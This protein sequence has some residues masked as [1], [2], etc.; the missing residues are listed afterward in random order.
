MH[1]FSHRLLL[2]FAIIFISAFCTPL[3]AQ[4]NLARNISIHV[5]NQRL[6]SVFKTMEERG[7]FYFSYN[8]NL[9]KA[10][11]LVSLDADNWTV[12]EVLDRMLMKRFEY[13]D[14]KGFIILRY[15][16][17]QL[18]LQ[19]EKS[20]TE[21]NE[22]TITGFIADELTGKK[23]QNASVYE[24]RL[25]QSTMTDQNGYFELHLKNEGNPVRLTVSKELYK[26]TTITFLNDV[27]VASR[28]DSG[29]FSYI[30]NDDI[31]GIAKTGLG[32]LLLS[33]RQQIQAANL[34]GLVAN[35]PFQAS[36]IPNVSTHGALSGQIV[37]QV[38][39][40][41]LGG[42]NAG[43]RGFEMGI[44]F[45]L[46]KGDVESVQIAGVFNIVG[47]SV[48]GLQFGG[49]YNNVLGDVSG[50][51][52]A[53]LHNNIK[54][55]LSGVQLSAYNHVKGNVSGLQ[56][57]AGNIALQKFE[58]MQLGLFNF[59]K[60]LRGVQLGLINVADTSS[61]F[62]L[63]LINYVRNGYNKLTISPNETLNANISL[64]S[65][66]RNFYTVYTGGMRVNE[67]SKI[68]G[69]GMGLGTVLDMSNRLSF[70]PEISSR[71]LY[72]GIWRYTNLL[73]RLDA[74]L[75]IKLGKKASIFAGPSLNFYYTKQQNA[76][77]GYALAQNLQHNFSSNQ[78]HSWWLGWNAGFN[79][80]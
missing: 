1:Y 35:A 48:S 19:T 29:L 49:L 58:G 73:N 72:E 67:N 40:N 33:T 17:L 22:Y 43:V 20:V 60:K 39:L 37:N 59:A 50:L 31:E 28:P 21:N 64:K 25:L 56:I 30:A 36:V 61:G 52:L 75:N 54:R 41:A 4:V 3:A 80:F 32:R 9:V 12:K 2:F 7:S 8:S 45:N 51:Q 78:H 66:S 70:N 76:V 47:G 57:G 55:E 71:Y 24:K 44:I 10:D 6:G 26:D 77:N 42:Y 13:K 65:G 38:S 69:F 16:P 14:A 15:A 5:K 74:N 11:S 53:I 23:I 62:S 18:D 34:R 68:Y 46:D 79:F 27:R 63:G